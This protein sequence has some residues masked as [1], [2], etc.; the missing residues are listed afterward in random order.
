M[1]DYSENRVLDFVANDGGTA[2]DS[3]FQ[4]GELLTLTP[5]P[6]VKA[7]KTAGDIVGQRRRRV[8]PKL[9]QDFMRWREQQ[10]RMK[11]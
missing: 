11:Q 6:K 10:Q 2:L 7:A 4:L 8:D 5:N 9:V 3:L 1:S